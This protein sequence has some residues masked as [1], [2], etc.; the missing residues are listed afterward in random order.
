MITD[1]PIR[2]FTVATALLV[3]CLVTAPPGAV[4]AEPAG[5]TPAEIVVKVDLAAG[6]QISDVQAQYPIAVDSALLASRGIY[7]VHATDP[8]YQA[9]KAKELADKIAQ[10]DAVVYAEPDLA[11][12]L[13]D[14]RFHAWP[15]G[16]AEDAGTDPA[17]WWDQQTSSRLMLDDAHR[18]SLGAGVLVAVLDTGADLSHPALQGRVMPGW[19]YVDDDAD[20]SEEAPGIPDESGHIDTAYGHGTFV[21]GVTAM[22]APEALIMPERVLDSNGRGSIFTVAQAI[23]DAT[24]AGADV[25]NL[26]FGMPKQ[27]RSRLLEEAIRDARKQGV[28]IVA[29]AGNTA[30]DKQQYPAAQPEVL[31]VAALDS[32]DDGLASFSCWG[33]WVDVAAPGDHIAGPV[34]GGRY[35][36]WRGTSIAAPIVAGQV[37]LLRSISPASSAT[38]MFDAVTR[39][40]DKI[41]ETRKV[42][43]GSI[44]VL[45]SLTFAATHR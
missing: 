24:A 33:D 44:D 21:S 15:E 9:D 41:D 26:S 12:S 6:H 43:N 13:I 23:L 27:V 35:A 30:N 22:V 16:S 11:T 7:R 32:D 10:S 19:D 20:P 14:T 2:T 42:H 4:A 5:D 40:T 31:S 38:K 29:S 17:V 37:A 25:I 34:P 1:R 45:N 28:V 36:W 39:T 18:Q 3:A 8:K